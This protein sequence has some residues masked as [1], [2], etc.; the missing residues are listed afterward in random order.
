MLTPPP[1]LGCSQ[2][3]IAGLLLFTT[4]DRLLQQAAAA[5]AT[6]GPSVSA[7]AEAAAAAD[8]RFD[9]VGVGMLA[10][11]LTA[12]GFISVVQQMVMQ[13]RGLHR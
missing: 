11:S 9:L 8:M 2:V 3:L 12:S 6:A 1:R 5:V 13:Q 10:I 4:A 7:A